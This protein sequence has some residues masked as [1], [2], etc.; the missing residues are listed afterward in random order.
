MR[1]DEGAHRRIIVPSFPH[2]R[3]AAGQSSRSRVVLALTRDGRA[4]PQTERA[5]RSN[6]MGELAE[7][8]EVGKASR[9]FLCCASALHR[10]V[11][12]GRSATLKGSSQRPGCVRNREIRT[13]GGSPE[14]DWRGGPLTRQKLLHDS[15]SFLMVAARATQFMNGYAAPPLCLQTTATRSLPQPDSDR[16]FR[17]SSVVARWDFWLDVLV[18]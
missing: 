15:R 18:R 14:S 16:N 12:A 17:N 7:V 11:P 2:P 9:Q 13:K 1:R 6:C 10:K 5:G 4:G 8:G 3:E